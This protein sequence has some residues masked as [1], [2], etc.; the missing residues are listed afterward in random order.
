MNKKQNG[1]YGK[2]AAFFLVAVIFLCI[3][4]V[5]ASGWQAEDPNEPDSGDV[6][7][8]EGDGADENTDGTEKPSDTTPEIYLPKHVNPITGVECSAEEAAR[9]HLAFIFDSSAPTY[10]LSSSDVLIEFP[11]E[12]GVTRL[13]AF[14]SDS[15]KLGKIGSLA[16]TR[17]YIS[18]LIRPF[19]APLVALG[20]D[21]SVSYEH[22]D[23]SAS[24]LDLSQSVGY[25]Y[26]EYS[27]FNYS[28]GH[29]IKAGLSNVRPAAPAEGVSLPFVFTQFGENPVTGNTPALKVTIPYSVGSETELTYSVESGDVYLFS[30]NGVPKTDMLTGTY[31][32]FKNVIVLFADSVTYETAKSTQTVMNT[33]TSGSGYYLT[34]GTSS[35]ITWSVDEGGIYHFSD[36]NGS[37]LTVNRGKTYIGFVK[38]SMTDAVK[39]Q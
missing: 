23:L 38:S 25:H 15:E 10:G 4:G 30:K 22:Y 26:T 39:F 37:P 14:I 34:E 17:G 9:G 20:S 1:N 27:H 35:Y 31:T 33:H 16:P 21:D 6:V 12:H 7:P 24:V 3:C 2:L 36:E 8:D 11:T 19:G 32:G 18:N 5:A 29:L 13:L 28:N